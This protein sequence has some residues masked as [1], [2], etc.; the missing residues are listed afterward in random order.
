MMSMIN[1]LR[2]NANLPPLGFANPF[3]YESWATSSTSPAFTDIIGGQTQAHGCCPS[4]FTAVVGWEP[5]CGL[6]SPD[7]SVLSQLALSS[8]VFPY[9]Y[10]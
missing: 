1:T 7:F 5:V 10:E 4:G 9:L 6:G 8:S 3:L 2:F